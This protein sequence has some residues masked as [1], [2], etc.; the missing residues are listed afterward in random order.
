MVEVGWRWADRSG[1]RTSSRVVDE[2][3]TRAHA[4]GRYRDDQLRRLDWFL[5]GYCRFGRARR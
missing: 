2:A 4:K 3:N 5:L 1:N